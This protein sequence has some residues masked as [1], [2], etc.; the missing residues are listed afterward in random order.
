MIFLYQLCVDVSEAK[1]GEAS[2][3][4]LVET[5][6]QQGCFVKILSLKFKAWEL[7]AQGY[8]AYWLRKRFGEFPCKL[9]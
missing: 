1:P 3:Q 4:W 7:F 6:E 5:K 2:K 9:D 8:K